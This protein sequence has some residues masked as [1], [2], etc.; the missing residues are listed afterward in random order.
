MASHLKDFLAARGKRLAQQAVRLRAA[1]T[2]MSQDDQEAARALAEQIVAELDLGDWGR[3]VPEV[4]QLLLSVT[5]DGIRVAFAQIGV[6]PSAE[7]TAQVNLQALDFARERAAELVGMR[8]GADGALLE[9]PDA[10]W[11]ISDATRTLLRGDIVSALEEGL[12]NQDFAAHLEQSYAFS[13]DRA[14]A[15]ARTEIARAD[16]EGNMTAWRDSGVVGGKEW[17]L[18]A[19]HEDDDECDDAAALGVVPLDDDF[20]GIGDP[21]AHPRCQCDV[22]PVLA[23]EMEDGA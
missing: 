6:T 20:G 15:I 8:I 1:L 5:E 3:L 21:P 7:L 10:E 22:S 12:S 4:Q 9:N 14:E 23:S 13:A 16:V 2:K 11:A 17:F 18:S 19:D